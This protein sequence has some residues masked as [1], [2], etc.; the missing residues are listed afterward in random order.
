M[1]FHAKFELLVLGHARTAILNKAAG[2]RNRVHWKHDRPFL[3]A[4][5]MEPPRRHRQGRPRTKSTSIGPSPSSSSPG[6]RGSIPKGNNRKHR[7]LIGLFDHLQVARHRA[8]VGV[9][10]EI[11]RMLVQVFEA[12]ISGSCSR[13]QKRRCRRLDYSAGQQIADDNIT[14]WL[15]RF[16]HVGGLGCDLK[17]I[18]MRANNAIYADFVAGALG[19]A[20]PPRQQ[21]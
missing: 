10:A 18:P 2:S 16:E 8:L 14:I 19:H 20:V 4:L 7:Q 12:P 11:D 13:C 1:I 6:S 9:T 17:R 15:A 5:A 21:Q 3:Q